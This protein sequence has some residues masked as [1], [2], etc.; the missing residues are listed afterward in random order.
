MEERMRGGTRFAGAGIGGAL[1][2]VAGCSWA[3]NGSEGEELRALSGQLTYRERI[4]LPPTAVAFIELADVPVAESESRTISQ[5]RITPVTQVPIRFTLTYDPATVDEARYYALRARIE[6]GAGRVLFSTPEVVSI[7]P[8]R[9]AHVEILL[10]RLG[11][12][13]EGVPPGAGARPPQ[14]AAFACEGLRF[15]VEYQDSAT[16]RMLL[17]EDTVL[18]T[19]VVTASG[20]RYRDERID[21]WNRG[22]AATVIVDGRTYECRVA[23]AANDP[24]ER[25]RAAGVHLRAIGQEPGWMIEVTEEVELVLVTDY[26]RRRERFEHPQRDTAEPGA[27]IYRA[28]DGDRRVQVVVRTQRCGDTMSGEAFELTV[29]VR[30]GDEELHGCGRRLH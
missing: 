19:S 1:L 17:A 30:I 28:A 9:G 23:T 22:E 3:G 18:L 26:G 11:R 10:H 2:F 8:W 12:G 16:M 13:L 20:A 27:T 21:F 6:D 29:T 5:Q 24:W 15:S 14:P 25:A 7:E 4:A